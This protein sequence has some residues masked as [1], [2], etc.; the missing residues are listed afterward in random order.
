MKILVTGGVGFIGAHLVKKLIDLKHE[1]L[2]VD[3]LKVIGGIP[4]IH[5]K[6]K[7]LR[8][9]ILDKKT[10]EKIKKWKPQIIYHLAAQSGGESAYDDPKYDYLSNGYGTYLLS[11]LA[12]ELKVKK[13]IY[14][15]SVAVYG[16]N[17]QKK[18]NEKTR[19]NPDSIYGIS[20]YAGEM[21]INQILKNTNIQ[22]LIFR[23][24]NTYGPG[25]DLNFLKKGMVS[26]Y[27]SYLWRNKPIIVKGSLN[28]FRNYQ[29]IDDIINILILSLQNKRLNKNEVINL[30][31]GKAEKVKNLLKKIFKVNNKKK[32]KV[33]ETKGTPGDSFGYDASNTYLKSKFKNYTFI[34]L[35]K[36]LKLYFQ[37]I[38]RVPKIKNLK[39]YHPFVM[40]KK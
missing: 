31:T 35:E 6:C 19:I 39:K 33:L 13:F 29:Y 3:N 32:Y 27:C 24:F 9:D 7:F 25:E 2:I 21:F 5:P 40:T 36:G 17:P 38:N 12:K 14:T 20:K 10:L 4:F 28:R 1:V 18:I 26:I 15:S 11:L 8:G 22:T 30:T 23:V 37:W 34:P 16:S